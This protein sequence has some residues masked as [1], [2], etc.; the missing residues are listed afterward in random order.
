MSRHSATAASVAANLSAVRASIAD[1][2]RG[3]S[4]YNTGADIITQ[5]N[6]SAAVILRSAEG[7]SYDAGDSSQPRGSIQRTYDA[8]N[9]DIGTGAIPGE[10]MRVDVDITN[11]EDGGGG[12][13]G[14]ID[15]AD[16]RI[17]ICDVSRRGLPFLAHLIN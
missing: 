4:F 16:E 2:A 8:D 5:H 17:S 14:D 13:H 10:G 3:N 6:A 15:I 11:D 12:H 9:V 7:D 1:T